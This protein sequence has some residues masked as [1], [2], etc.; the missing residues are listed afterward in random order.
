MTD[1]E[2]G[3]AGSGST[4]RPPPPIPRP[5]GT[6]PGGARP[7]LARV[8]VIDDDPVA[9]AAMRYALTR[10][11]RM[12][13]WSANG[14]SEALMLLAETPFDVVVTDVQM[15]MMSGLQLLEQLTHA[16]PTIPVIV[17]TASSGVDT[18]LSL[19]RSRA[20]AVLFKPIDAQR[21]VAAVTDVRAH[22]AA[23]PELDPWSHP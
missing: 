18:A 16:A 13:V 7:T 8:L 6:V 23:D 20:A 15:P 11:G 19:V 1:V 17:V 9:L 14:P 2:P 4:V 10:S 22:A 3:R 12:V 5:R 21:L